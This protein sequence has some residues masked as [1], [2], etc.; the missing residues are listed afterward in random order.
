MLDLQERV[1]EKEGRTQLTGV[2]EAALP[3][4]RGLHHGE[5]GDDG[6]GAQHRDTL[7][8]DSPLDKYEVSGV[9]NPIVT[10]PE[11]KRNMHGNPKNKYA[12]GKGKET[13]ILPFHAKPII[14][15]HGH[16]Q[17]DS[18]RSALQ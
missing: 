15:M 11:Q 7:P 14:P 12:M 16:W 10:I 2:V 3:V 13:R 18:V 6:S 17:D 5:E 4:E 1:A 9:R 8:I